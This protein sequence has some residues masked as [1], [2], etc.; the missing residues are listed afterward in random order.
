MSI[1]LLNGALLKKQKLKPSTEFVSESLKE[2]QDLYLKY[3]IRFLCT[4]KD[5]V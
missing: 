4:K 5:A 2:C 1:K 3:M